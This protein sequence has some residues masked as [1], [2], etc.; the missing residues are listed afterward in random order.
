LFFILFFLG[1]IQG[2]AASIFMHPDAANANFSGA[3]NII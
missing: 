3:E 1:G 2:K